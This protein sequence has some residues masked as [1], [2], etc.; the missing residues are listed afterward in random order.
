MKTTSLEM[1]IIS[2]HSS[3]EIHLI[4]RPREGGFKVFLADQEFDVESGTTQS[5]NLRLWSL[6]M[7]YAVHRKETTGIATKNHMKSMV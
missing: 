1:R 2:S 5:G 7:R 6:A 3:I 4:S